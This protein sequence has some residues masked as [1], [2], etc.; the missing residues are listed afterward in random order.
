MYM[1]LFIGF[2][3]TGSFH[4]NI[5][6]QYTETHFETSTK[7]RAEVMVIQCV[8]EC[9]CFIASQFKGSPHYATALSSTMSE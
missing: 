9:G 2:E 6:F 1:Y 5:L 8:E 3:E 7:V 4:R